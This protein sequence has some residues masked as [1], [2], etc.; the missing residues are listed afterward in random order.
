MRR[1]ETDIRLLLDYDKYEFDLCVGEVAIN[2]NDTDKLIHNRNKCLREAKEIVDHH[3]ETG[4]K[5][6]VLVGPFK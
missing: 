2:S 5:E 1:F 6:N 4:M 3:L